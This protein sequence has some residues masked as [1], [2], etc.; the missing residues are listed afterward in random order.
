[1]Q[2]GSIW[3]II[4][5]PLAGEKSKPMMKIAL[6]TFVLLLS[7]SLTQARNVG[8]A[9]STPQAS[10]T[11]AAN[12]TVLFGADTLNAGIKMMWL[13]AKAAFRVGVLAE[14]GGDYWNTVNIG[15]GSFASGYNTYASGDYATAMGNNTTASGS[16]STA[17]GIRTEA[18]GYYSTAM[19]ET[20]KA[21]GG[22][23]TAMGYATKASGERST[24]MGFSTVA[25]AYTSLSLGQ[26]NDS[27]A[28]SNKFNWFLTD[29]LLILGNGLS[30]NSRSNA[31]V[32]YQNGNTDI[33]GYTRLGKAT[34]N[35]P[36]IKTKKITGYNTPTAANPNTFTFV[37]HGVTASKILSLSVLVDVAGDYQFLPHS[38]QTGYLYTA[39]LDPA[40]GGSPNIAIGVNSAALSASVMGRP[41]K[42]FITY[43]E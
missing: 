29:P 30:N 24:A 16:I 15:F 36:K 43:E 39:N 42:I 19:G 28:S 33:N 4:K 25:Q 37:P 1:M 40:G 21:L 14:V 20:T 12:K 8:I 22:I 41:I 6:V 34:D 17:M 27:I 10:F 3:Q 13:P 31:L 35:A 23:S 7:A 32:V 9:T 38:T 26:Y 11:V 5:Q 18:S 2:A